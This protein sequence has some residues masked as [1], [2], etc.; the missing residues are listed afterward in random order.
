MLTKAALSFYDGSIAELGIGAGL[1]LTSGDADPTRTNTDSGYGLILD[2]SESDAD[3]TNYA[4]TAFP[5]AGLTLTTLGTD[6]NDSLAQSNE[7]NEIFEHG[8][9]N[10]NVVGSLGDDVLMEGMVSMRPF[11]AGIFLQ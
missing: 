5:D 7:F 4:N 10:D 6:E 2:L 9:G 8:D 3:F 1:F 11:L